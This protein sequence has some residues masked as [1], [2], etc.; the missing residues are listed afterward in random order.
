MNLWYSKS[1]EDALNE[2]QTNAAL[3]LTDAEVSERQEK[4]GPN[5]LE[6]KKKKSLIS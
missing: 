5:R 4:F 1:H 3:G 6:G 2:L